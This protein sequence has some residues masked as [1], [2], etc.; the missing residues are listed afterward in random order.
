[1]I[2]TLSTHHPR[3]F[4]ALFQH[5]DAEAGA[6]VLNNRQPRRRFPV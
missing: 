3:P 4:I 5:H 1:L 6:K 2:K